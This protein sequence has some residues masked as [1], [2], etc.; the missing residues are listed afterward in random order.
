MHCTYHFYKKYIEYTV[1]MPKPTKLHT[2]GRPTSIQK[3][4][5]ATGDKQSSAGEIDHEAAVRQ[6][7]LEL[8]WCIQKLEKTVSQK[9]GNESEKSC[10]LPSYIF[11]LIGVVD[12]SYCPS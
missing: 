3:L 2:K 1:E 12:E 6:F 5:N 8:C 10:K 11:F 4:P 9:N 7:E